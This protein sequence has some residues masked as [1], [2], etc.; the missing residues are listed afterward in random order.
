M[1][2][3][4]ARPAD[5]NAASSV[6]RGGESQSTSVIRGLGGFHEIHPVFGTIRRDALPGDRLIYERLR[7]RNRMTRRGRE[8]SRSSCRRRIETSANS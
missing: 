7:T 6:G 5:R 4:P 3:Q 8:V 1:D 2:A